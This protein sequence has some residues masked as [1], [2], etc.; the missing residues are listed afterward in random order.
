MPNLWGPHTGIL[1]VCA[2]SGAGRTDDAGAH[3]NDNGALGAG[4]LRR[5]QD[6]DQAVKSINE[7]DL[8][9]AK[10]PVRLGE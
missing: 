5:T 10:S 8:P 1:A 4:L 2:G 7:N 9:S 3:M 6:S